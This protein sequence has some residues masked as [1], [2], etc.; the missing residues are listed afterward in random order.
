VTRLLLPDTALALLAAGTLA[1]RYAAY[2]IV[3]ARVY[4]AMALRRF[5]Q[6]RQKPS[7]RLCRSKEE[8]SE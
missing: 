4:Q 2:V 7:C 3:D 1:L 8:S 6:G 5:E